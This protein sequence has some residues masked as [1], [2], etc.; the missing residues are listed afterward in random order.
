MSNMNNLRCMFEQCAKRGFGPDVYIQDIEI[1][2]EP[3]SD[4]CTVRFEM[5]MF[6]KQLRE[7]VADSRRSFLDALYH[8]PIV[9]VKAKKVIF[10]APATIVLWEDGTKTVVKCSDEDEYDEEKGLAMCYCK[11]M[12]GEKRYKTDIIKEV[13]KYW[14]ELADFYRET[15]ILSKLDSIF[16]KN[17][18]DEGY[19]E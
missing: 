3:Y 7:I 1:R 12:L 9:N 8:K 19:Q 18:K 4:T 14:K 5:C 10:N 2:Q 6:N 17:Q 15:S 11:R 13:K 16:S